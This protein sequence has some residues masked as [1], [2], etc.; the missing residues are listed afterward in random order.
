MSRKPYAVVV[1]AN[2]LLDGDVVYLTAAHTWSRHL[3]QALVLTDKTDAEIALAHADTQT[4]EVVGCYL[5]DVRQSASGP[6]PVHFR[7]DFRRR[8]PSNYAHGKQATASN[9]A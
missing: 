5:A 7:E 3:E 1:T 8:G 9:A 2:A 6:Q 4:A